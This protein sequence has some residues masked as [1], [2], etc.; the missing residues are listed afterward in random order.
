MPPTP[1]RQGFTLIELMVLITLF[2]ALL[3][4]AAPP[5]NGYLNSNRLEIN[6]DR[7]A[8]DLQYTRSIAIAN[9]QTMR[10]QATETGYRIVEPGSGSIIRERVFDGGCALSLAVNA[11]FFPWGMAESRVI[12][13]ANCAGS[14]TITLLPTGIVEVTE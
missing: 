2:T 13:M 8:A 1:P 9:G 11:D 7:L 3:V 5:I 14:R 4:V 10:F 6:A 12:N